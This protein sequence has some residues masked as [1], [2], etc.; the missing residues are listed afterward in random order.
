M[1]AA[2]K[3]ATGE[4]LEEGNKFAQWVNYPNAKDIGASCFI[5]TLPVFP[6]KV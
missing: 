3:P 4:N 5:Q 2:G 1:Y 6:M